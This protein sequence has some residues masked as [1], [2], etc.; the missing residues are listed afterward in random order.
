MLHQNYVT[1][2]KL[3][4]REELSYVYVRKLSNK[5]TQMGKEKYVIIILL[6]G[7]FKFL[8]ISHIVLLFPL[9][10]LNQ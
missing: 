7:A 9:L 5:I 10:T 4:L 3:E 2:V 8:Q 1:K 6:A